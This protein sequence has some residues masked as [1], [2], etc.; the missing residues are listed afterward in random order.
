MTA[1][2]TIRQAYIL[3]SPAVLLSPVL[4]F[5]AK[6]EAASTQAGDPLFRYAAFALRIHAEQLRSP[7]TMQPTVLIR[8]KERLRRLNKIPMATSVRTEI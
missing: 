4:G 8:A 6:A 7:A 5:V 3:F 2:R 1:G